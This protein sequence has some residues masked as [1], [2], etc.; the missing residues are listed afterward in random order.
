MS[1]KPPMKISEEADQK[2]LDMAKEQGNV[3]IQALRHMANEVADDGGEKPVG[4]YIVAYAIEDAEGMYWLQDGEL[5][6][7]EPDANIHIEVSVRDA[8]DH[9]FIPNLN[10]MVTLIDAD[11]NDVGRHEQPFVWH[12]W[13]YHYGRNWQVEK[14][15]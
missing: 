7:Q 9:R 3:Y 12:P 6:W 13:L 15:G 5:Q 14:S 8:S 10:I 4:D 11:G 2:Q 1:T